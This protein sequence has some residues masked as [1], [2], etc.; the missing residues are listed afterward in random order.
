VLLIY[1]RS[2]IVSVKGHAVIVNISIIAALRE[3]P[4]QKAAEPAYCPICRQTTVM[5]K[6][7]EQRLASIEVCGLPGPAVRPNGLLMVLR[8]RVR[9]AYLDL[10]SRGNGSSPA[11][12]HA[13]VMG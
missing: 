4:H 9:R 2:A 1:P 12:V 13:L 3:L 11:E 6:M 5:G 10:V 7:L 8:S